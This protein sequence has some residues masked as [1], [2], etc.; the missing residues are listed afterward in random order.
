MRVMMWQCS[1]VARNRIVSAAALSRSR[2]LN[3]QS[4]RDAVSEAL[5]GLGASVS[6]RPISAPP[7]GDAWYS[8]RAGDGTASVAAPSEAVMLLRADVEQRD[9]H[10]TVG[11]AGQKWL[12][13]TLS[14]LGHHDALRVCA[15]RAEA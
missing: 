1:R 12:L 13:R 5:R 8:L 15:H 2:C 14:R 6:E 9:Y 11:S 3:Q 10:L 4:A 7:A